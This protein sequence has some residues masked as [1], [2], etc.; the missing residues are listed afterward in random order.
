MIEI[1]GESILW[2]EDKGEFSLWLTA[3]AECLASL[4][5]HL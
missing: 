2:L 4:S 1:D 3:G 5:A